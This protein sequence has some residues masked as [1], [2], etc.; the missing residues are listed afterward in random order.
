MTREIVA[1]VANGSFALSLKNVIAEAVELHVRI[2]LRL[3]E[4]QGDLLRLDRIIIR[5]PPVVVVPDIRLGQVNDLRVRRGRVVAPGVRILLTR[6][7]LV[8]LETDRGVK[9]ESAPARSRDF[10]PVAVPGMPASPGHATRE[11]AGGDFGVRRL[12][13][14]FDRYP[15]TGECKAASFLG[16]GA[17][18][19]SAGKPAHSKDVRLPL[20]TCSLFL[21]RVCDGGR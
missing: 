16:M 14:A 18:D 3:L 4:A 2:Q 12:A 19:K 11:R 9:D 17:P 6:G 8:Y 1:Q 10:N 7:N 21:A 15:P 20:T 5:D 13:A